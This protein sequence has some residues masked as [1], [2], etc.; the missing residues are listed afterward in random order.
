MGR[1]IVRDFA[2]FALVLIFGLMAWPRAAHAS[3]SIVGDG[4]HGAPATIRIHAAIRRGDFAAFEAAVARIGTLTDAK[5]NDVPFITV[6]LDSPGGDVVEAV[7]IGRSIYQHFMMTLVRPGHECVSACVFILVAGAVHT[8]DDEASIGLH[9]PL[10]VSWSHM[11]GDQA[12]AKY[13]EL[14]AYLRDYFV[15]LGVSAAAW[16]IMMGT[17]SDG[18]RYFAPAELDRLGLRGEDPAWEKLYDLKWTGGRPRSLPPRDSYAALP[19]IAEIDE[20]YRNLVFMPG[21]YHPGADYFAGVKLP[22]VHFTWQSID[23]DEMPAVSGP[24]LP[25]LG[26]LLTSTVDW[27]AYRLRPEWVLLIAAVVEFLRNRRRHGIY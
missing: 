12:R 7:K 17:D 23:G 8:P 19:K 22:N 6:E 27:I 21:A 20:S 9:R 25:D 5:I 16:E 15:K 3:V 18:M 2:G 26:T 4:A 11:S 1:L 14:M 24:G 13:N 10:L